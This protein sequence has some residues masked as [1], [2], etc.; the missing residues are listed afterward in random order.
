MS[1]RKTTKR[2]SNTGLDYEESVNEYIRGV[3]SGKITAGRLVRLAVRRHLL[4]LKHAAKRG[5]EFVKARA[6]EVIQFAE[7]CCVHTKNSISGKAGD[8]LVLSP[9]Q[10]FILW[11]LFGWRRIDD[12]MRRFEKAFIEVAR[13]WGKSTF[14]AVIAL[15]LLVLDHPVEQCGELYSAATKE[16]QAGIIHRTAKRMASKSPSRRLRRLKRTKTSINNDA[17]DSFF[18][19]VGSDSENSDGLDISAVFLDEIHA[20]RERHR[21]LHERLTT[22][23]DAR[24]QPLAATTTTAGD[25]KSE[26]WIEEHEYA[27]DVVES[28]LTGSIVDDTVFAFICSIDNEESVCIDCRGTGKVKRRKCKRC[29]DGVQPADDPFAPGVTRDDV[30]EMCR[31]AN[32]N[33]GISVAPHKVLTKWNEAKHKSTSRNK[34][35]R[36]TANVRTGSF[37]RAID[38]LLW[39]R[40]NGKLSIRPGDIAFGGF[41]LARSSD[42]SAWCL[43]FPKKI[44]GVWKYQLLSKSYVCEERGEKLNNDRISRWIDSDS[45][46]LE[47][48]WGD[49]IDHDLIEEDIVEVSEIYNVK[50]WAYDKMFAGTI[51]QRLHNKH[52]L[53]IFPFTQAHRFYNEPI[54]KLQKLVKRR[55]II[56][57]GD[58]L[59][60][61]QAGNAVIDRDARDCW[62]PDKSS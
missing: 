34:F 42:W 62:M 55:E 6:N 17:T 48:H 60:A 12:G 47:Q 38:P 43:V 3:D 23:S 44:G 22:A 2:K 25:D 58:E 36:F 61:W 53:A 27:V 54:R 13:K 20:W 56:H 33:I 45:V 26:L 15:F 59:L 49:E 35:L 4:D 8:L 1:K 50:S 18:Q 57:G 40:C 21:G 5:F 29:V 10:R 52:G 37:E 32:P 39:A 31:K 16:K 41:D 7:T 30:V 11:V 24:L 51:A 14:A 9:S 28:V 46:R 19:M